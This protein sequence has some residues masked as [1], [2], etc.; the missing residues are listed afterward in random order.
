MLGVPWPH[1]QSVPTDSDPAVN[2]PGS[3]GSPAVSRCVNPGILG[4]VHVPEGNIHSE[5]RAVNEQK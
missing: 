4:M 1:H 2:T 3:G 5:R